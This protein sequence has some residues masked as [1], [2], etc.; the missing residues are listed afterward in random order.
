LWELNIE[1]VSPVKSCGTSTWWGRHDVDPRAHAVASCCFPVQDD[2][3]HLSWSYDDYEYQPLI[4]LAGAMGVVYIIEPGLQR[5]RRVLKGHGDV[6]AM[7]IALTS[8]V[9]TRF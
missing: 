4:A 6:S 1:D 3:F 9:R 5:I 7:Q 2:L 8:F